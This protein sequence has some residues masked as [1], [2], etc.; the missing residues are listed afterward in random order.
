MSQ[1][2]GP[3]P[4]VRCCVRYA[5][6]AVLDR[7]DGLMHKDVSKVELKERIFYSVSLTIFYM[8]SITNDTQM[9]KTQALLLSHFQ[10][11]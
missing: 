4:E 1:A 6:Q 8:E 7:V 10:L 5:A 3:E 9:N 2:E 11:N